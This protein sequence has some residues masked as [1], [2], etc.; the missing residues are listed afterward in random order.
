MA[1]ALQIASEFEEI[2][3]RILE[4]NGFSI[5]Q[6]PPDIADQNSDFVATLAGSAWAVEFR[7]YRTKRPQFNLIRLAAARLIDGIKSHEP[8]AGNMPLRGM[9]IV[10]VDLLPEHRIK[11]EEEFG[12]VFVDR[13]D[14][15]IWCRTNPD[16]HERLSMFL[17][18]DDVGNELKEGRQ[19]LNLLATGSEPRMQPEPDTTGSDLCDELRELKTGKTTWR[20]Y[21]LLCERILK[22]L[23]PSDLHGWYSQKRTDDGLNRFDFICRTKSSTEFWKFLI[24][25]LHSRYVLFEFKNYKARINQGQV[26]TTEKY[27]LERALRRVAI[28]FTRKGAHPN[29]VRMAQGAMREHGKLILILNDENICDMLIS[30]ESGEDPSDLL[31]EWA[32]DF[33]LSLPR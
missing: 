13:T 8:V 30:K 24:E 17:S 32:D 27:L 21:E 11:L 20:K 12:I 1:K 14:L 33:L 2:G 23:F 28:V 6:L 15:F 29:A 19:L 31:F 3:V 7:F 10:S 5:A 25:D 18:E 26:L 16:L 4:E 22:Y 9:L